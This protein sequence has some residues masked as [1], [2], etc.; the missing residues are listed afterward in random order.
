M[1]ER[2]GGLAGRDRREGTFSGVP[3]EPGTKASF[4]WAEPRSQTEQITEET[5]KFL[6]IERLSISY[7]IL[8]EPGT[9]YLFEYF[10]GTDIGVW[11]VK[12]K[13]FSHPQ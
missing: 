9:K 10:S 3:T 6:P 7:D 13:T 8:L 2:R 12:C 1:T 5:P 11:R 4:V